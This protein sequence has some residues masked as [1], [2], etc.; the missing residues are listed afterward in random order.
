MM[1]QGNLSR[2]GLGRIGLVRRMKLSVSER[3]RGWCW[4]KIQRL[5]LE[6]YWC[7][8]AKNARIIEYDAEVAS[9]IQNHI[10]EQIWSRG[11]GVSVDISRHQ[12]STS[13]LGQALAYLIPASDLLKSTWVMH[14]RVDRVNRGM[15]K[16]CRKKHSLGRWTST[17]R[18]R[19]RRFLRLSHH[20]FVFVAEY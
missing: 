2:R 11:T 4:V 8:L 1:S 17:L 15:A 18:A 19:P 5:S 13:P 10:L 6:N 7:M 14:Y 12:H 9:T 20:G 16:E 3:G